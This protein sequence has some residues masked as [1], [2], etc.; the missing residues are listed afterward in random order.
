MR[1]TKKKVDELIAIQTT[2]E[3]KDSV[4][5]NLRALFDIRDEDIT[6]WKRA[7]PSLEMKAR[8]FNFVITR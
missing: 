7:L 8:D 1:G 2:V 5:E 3:E 6:S 4:L